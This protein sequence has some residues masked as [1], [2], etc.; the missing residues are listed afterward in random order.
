MVG[1]LSS[2]LRDSPD[3]VWLGIRKTGA[4]M[5][6]RTWWHQKWYEV[7]SEE[8]SGFKPQAVRKIDAKEIPYERLLFY[9]APTGRYAPPDKKVAYF[10]SDNSTATCETK[11]QFR[12]NPELSSNEVRAYYSGELTPEPGG[13]G[14]PLEHDVD[15][16]VV[17]A[18]LR[19][20]DNLLFR[21]I[22]SQNGWVNASEFSKNVAC[23]LDHEGKHQTQI[24]AAAAFDRG[25]NGVWFQSV[26]TPKGTYVSSGECLV[27]FEGAENL[28]SLFN[29]AQARWNRLTD[30]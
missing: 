21:Y 11:A 3:S 5:S 1:D 29:P 18:D 10:G 30:R 8:P 23:S 27:L 16:S 4:D 15:D 13:Y 12:E 6:W 19:R 28:V 25:F 26:R 24:I 7:P 14:F 2:T 20:P 9:T 17:L 22:A